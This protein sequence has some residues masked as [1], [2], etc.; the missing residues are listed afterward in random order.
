MKV[1]CI[2]VTIFALGLVCPARNLVAAASSEGR[3]NVTLAATPQWPPESGIE[4][5]QSTTAPIIT[6]LSPKEGPINTPVM[7][8]GRNF[9]R[10]NNT[11]EFQGE[12]DFAAGPVGSEDG[13][14]LQFR[15]SARCPSDQPLCPRFQPRPGLYKLTVTND[16]GKSNAVEFRLLRF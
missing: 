10:K 3:P 15:V 12:T 13:T 14:S 9:L 7:V 8:H 4:F 16:G 5:A 1:V 6:S 11:V 2:L